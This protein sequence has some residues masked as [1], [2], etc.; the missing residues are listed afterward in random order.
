MR[1][2]EPL[3]HKDPKY[4]HGI[5]F[6][7]PSPSRLIFVEQGQIIS[8]KG[9]SENELFETFLAKV[10]ALPPNQ[11]TYALSKVSPRDSFNQTLRN[12][13]F[14]TKSKLLE[15]Q[16][17]WV[18][19]LLIDWIQD[20]SITWKFEAVNHASE[21]WGI[22]IQLDRIVLTSSILRRST[23]GAG[24]PK[25]RIRVINHQFKHLLVG[26]I[27]RLKVI[28]N[29]HEWIPYSVLASEVNQPDV[30]WGLLDYLKNTGHIEVLED[31]THSQFKET[32][33]SPLQTS[34]HGRRSIRSFS[35]SISLTLGL[36]I[37][38]GVLSAW[39]TKKKPIQ[40]A[41]YQLL[42]GSVP[43]REKNHWTIVINIQANEESLTQIKSDF[44]ERFSLYF[45]PSPPG[46]SKFRV[47]LGDFASYSEA[48]EVLNSLE[49]H[50]RP[51]SNGW[52]VRKFKD[53]Q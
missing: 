47:S 19:Q 40:P 6:S 36:L 1:F 42:E 38:I 50:R 51:Y 49:L 20:E 39:V 43:L 28:L 37:I 34:G 27:E 48:L 7:S 14:L 31:E 23:I 29:S 35:L 26:P 17:Q 5:W 2:F 8:L 46:S 9:S 25:I 15:L 41:P 33:G 21:N 4:R 52:G 13:G 24:S 16:K 3:I 18:E 44:G 10:N 22:D 45:D 32:T 12:L 11:L 30:L 53:L